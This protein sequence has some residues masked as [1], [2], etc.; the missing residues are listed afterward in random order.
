MR[1]DAVIHD[2]ANGVSVLRAVRAIIDDAQD[3]L[4]ALPAYERCF[5]YLWL[6]GPIVLLIERS[7]AD[8][9]LSTLGI[10]FV[11]R[12]IKRLDFACLKAV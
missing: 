10:A 11:C 2:D 5:H 6:M 3:A 1:L 8:I 12:V 4:F 7:P 9:W